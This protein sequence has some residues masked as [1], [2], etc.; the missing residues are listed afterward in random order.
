MDNQ[1]FETFKEVLKELSVKNYRAC[2]GFTDRIDKCKDLDDVADLLDYYSDEIYERMG[3]DSRDYEYEISELEDK[4]EYLES[5]IE[6]LRPHTETMHDK[7]K[8]DLFL[9]HHS[10]FDPWVFEDL[11]TKN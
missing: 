1:K 11:L 8:Y 6:F 10:K 9:E 7:M 4:V 5:E 3:G 2:S